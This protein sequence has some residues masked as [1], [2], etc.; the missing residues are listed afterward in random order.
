[1]KSTH[2]EKEHKVTEFPK[3]CFW[4]EA[5]TKK[6]NYFTWA[7][8]LS[9]VKCSPILT[10]PHTVTRGNVEQWL[11]SGCFTWTNTPAHDIGAIYHCR[12]RNQVRD[13]KE[14]A[15]VLLYRKDLNPCNLAPKSLFLTI[16]LCS[17][18]SIQFEQSSNVCLMLSEFQLHVSRPCHVCLFSC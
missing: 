13:S 10:S 3:F 11:H 16:T 14:L 7:G 2:L 18:C 17:I 1:M 9:S 4:S 6:K 15:Q 8:S 12:H 5:E